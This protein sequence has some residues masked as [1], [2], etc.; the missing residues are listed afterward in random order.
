M[1]VRAIAMP[2]EVWQNSEMNMFFPVEVAIDYS[3]RPGSF[4]NAFCPVCEH[5]A[6]PYVLL[7]VWA[8][9]ALVFGTAGAAWAVSKGRRGGRWWVICALLLP[10]GLLWLG[11]MS[12][13][14]HRFPPRG[15]TRIPTTV[16]PVPCPD[17]SA[18]NH[19]AAK[20]C[21]GCGTALKAAM[22]SEVSAL[23]RT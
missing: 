3:T 4:I 22:E 10:L 17:C 15:L 20:V 18:T 13:R 19:P 5:V 7:M 9:V 8:V 16:E 2:V 6:S 11:M 1:R 14:P 21:G 23:G 12:D